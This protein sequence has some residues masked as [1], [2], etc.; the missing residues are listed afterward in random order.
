MMFNW[1]RKKGATMQQ[2]IDQMRDAEQARADATA[3]VTAAVDAFDESGSDRDAKALAAA[4]DAERLATEHVERARRLL[5]RRIRELGDALISQHQAE[6]DRLRGPVTSEIQAR[7]SVAGEKVSKLAGQLRDAQAAQ[8][9]IEKELVE[10][11]DGVR[12]HELHIREA[13]RR[14]DEALARDVAD[15]D[16]LRRLV[17]GAE[18]LQRQLGG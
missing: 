5:P 17:L 10:V 6:I 8:S 7:L 2:L 3:S 13:E 11:D 9:V 4:R 14:R 16:E 12:R 15:P 18:L 1:V